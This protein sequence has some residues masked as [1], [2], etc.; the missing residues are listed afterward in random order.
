M[1]NKFLT[2]EELKYVY[3]YTIENYTYDEPL[4]S[5]DT[6]NFNKL[7]SALYAPQRQYFNHTLYPTLEEQASVLFYE[8]IKLHPFI[9]GNKRVACVSLLTFL[10]INEFWIDMRWKELY[11]LAQSVASSVSEDR[12]IIQEEIV[13]RIKNNIKRISLEDFIEG[14]NHY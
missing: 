5:F 14:L 4:N 2:L 10:A 3:E 1:D 6:A 7:E 11:A 8:I 9:N 13:K 12:I